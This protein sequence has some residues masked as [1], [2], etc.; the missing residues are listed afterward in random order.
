MRHLAMTLQV[1]F[2]LS[3]SDLRHF[4]QIMRRARDAA[5]ARD[6]AE[7][8]A[9]GEAL[10]ESM[11]EAE[12]PDYVHARFARLR[13]MI[14]MVRDEEWRIPALERGRVVSALSYFL[15]PEDLIP[16]KVPGLGFIDDAIMI[17]LVGRE[18]RHELEAYT[19]FC[20][21]RE[22]ERARGDGADSP[23]PPEGWLARKRKALQ[24]RMRRRSTTSPS[25]IAPCAYQRHHRCRT[26]PT[27]PAAHTAV[28]P[29]NSAVYRTS[30]ENSAASR[31]A[32]SPM[33]TATRA[34]T[35]R[36]KAIDAALPRSMPVMTVSGCMLRSANL[37]P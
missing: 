6:E 21:F 20:R 8:L 1:T 2:E 36:P 32:S 12:L 5:R 7:V 37:C 23:P 10:L 9:A 31:G 13:T 35:A 17:E 4:K 24:D 26:S 25:H 29:M 30:V 19:D 27:K 34:T 15:E 28:I 16:D 22:R 14:D 33:R 18:L 11:D 3:L